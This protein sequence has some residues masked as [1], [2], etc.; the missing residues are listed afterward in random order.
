LGERRQHAGDNRSV[1][2]WD[3]A[4]IRE[5][6]SAFAQERRPTYKGHSAAEIDY[7]DREPTPTII[8]DVIEQ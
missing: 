8:P 5:V 2:N 4:V 7:A 6:V 1:S 3:A